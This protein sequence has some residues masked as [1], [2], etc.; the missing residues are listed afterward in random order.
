MRTNA[1]RLDL[2][3]W[4]G[5]LRIDV[6]KKLGSLEPKSPSTGNDVTLTIPTDGLGKAFYSI[7]ADNPFLGF[8]A[9][10]DGRVVDTNH[11]RGEF[12]AI[13][14]RHPWRFSV[15]KPTGDIW[16][17]IVGQDM[18]E[19][20]YKLK[21]GGNYGWPYYE[22]AHL[23]VPLYGT[24]THP[25]FRNPPPGF[26]LD[27]PLFEYPHNSV[28]GADPS[29]AG[30]DVNGS[31]FYRGTAIPELTN[32]YLFGDFDTGGNVWA[33]RISNN[34]VSVER[35]TGMTGLSAFGADPRTGEVLMCNYLQNKIQKLVKGDVSGSTFPSKLS[36]TG[37]FADL[38]TLT[39]NPGIVSYSPN[40]TFWSDY[41]LK[42]R[43]FTIPDLVSTVNFT[44]NGGWGLPTGMKWIKHFDLE[45]NRGNPATKKRIETRVLVKTAGGIYGVSYKWNDTQDE[46][47]L[48]G[49]SG[50]LFQLTVTNNGVPFQQ[51]W[52]IPS[53]SSCL[54]C[55]TPVAGFALTF[56][57]REM[58]KFNGMNGVNGNQIQTMS[59]GGYFSATVPNVHTLPAFAVATDT[60]FSLEY[61]VRSYLA[62]N[63]VQCH[64]PGGAGQGNWD[65]RPELTL[66]QTQMINGTPVAN[67]G[68]NPLNK[69]I[70]PGDTNH[71]VLLMRLENT[72]GFSR[73]PP[74]ATH[75]LDLGSIALVQNWITQELPGHLTYAQWIT[76]YPSLVGPAADP[77]ADPDAD[78][79]NNYFEYLTGTS[80][81]NG[82]D[83]WKPTIAVSGGQV[84]VGFQQVPN[85]GVVIDVSTD[86]NTWTPWDVP[87]NQPF[88]SSYSRPSLLSGPVSTVPPFQFFRA[89][90]IQP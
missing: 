23:T 20:V 25:G 76:N 14:M 83:A 16:V 63:C 65:A 24:N 2:A 74:L 46:A 47:F 66:A 64:Q 85:L 80:P 21:K 81:L 87:G 17:G 60:N 55:H 19:G 15:D 4:S 70:V 77:G 67:D 45:L 11:L 82:G 6:D 68:G 57:T 7:P 32:A 56:N 12:Y 26:V 54:S 50:D 51:D 8:T 9:D 84:Y 42:T 22:A 13:G 53:R 30:L 31:Y 48:V 62:V 10:A 44:S 39:P 36:D 28:G 34:V 41:A 3:L 86:L 71:S 78:G 52:E 43:W 61:R 88:F 69:I 49:D 37:I 18:Y 40:V 73:M 89:R 59:A 72:N 90:L 38:G 75:Q 33:M 29:F 27:G 79:A 35:L 1:Q 5:M 58:N